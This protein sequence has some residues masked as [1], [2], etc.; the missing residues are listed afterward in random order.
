MMDSHTMK[1]AHRT[2][3]LKRVDKFFIR[4]LEELLPPIST[5]NAK[6]TS[7]DI[8]RGV[9][10]AVTDND[11]VE[12][13]TEHQREL[14]RQVPSGDLVHLRLGVLG[15][16]MVLE[17]FNIL[18]HELLVRMGKLEPWRAPVPL[19]IDFHNIPYFGVYRGGH[20]VGVKKE[21]GTKWGYQFVSSQVVCGRRCTLHA[22]PT[23]QFDRK[24]ELLVQ[25]LDVSQRHVV[26]SMTYLDREF[27]T[28][29]C[30][31]LLEGRGSPYLMPARKDKKLVSEMN[32]DAP[33]SRVVGT[34]GWSYHRKVRPVG[35]KNDQVKVQTVFLYRPGEDEEDF[36][37]VTNAEVNDGNVE[38]LADGYSGR[39]GIETGYRMKEMVRGK[40][41]SQSHSVRRLFHLLSVLLYNLWQLMDSLL[42]HEFGEARLPWGYAIRLKSVIRM[43]R[44]WSE[45][46][47]GSMSI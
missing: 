18:N 42:V 10:G 15:H 47:G 41:C 6:Y 28:V 14:G 33:L 34:R 26:P 39:W 22:I 30:L 36:A 5:P 43:I 9:L 23:G 37:F 20:V 29:G 17:A 19:A 31:R 40:T 35:R 11:F 24:E 3:M 12:G 25:L 2:P 16:D 32:E 8:L 13:W 1:P 7:R 38:A 27:Y 44:L 46:M 45:G 4:R 21:K